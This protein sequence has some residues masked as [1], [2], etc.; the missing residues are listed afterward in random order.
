MLQG[1]PVVLEKLLIR[2]AAVMLVLTSTSYTHAQPNDRS[3]EVH[4]IDELIQGE[5][6]VSGHI[7]TGGAWIHDDFADGMSSMAHFISAS[8]VLDYSLAADWSL[9]SALGF[10][11]LSGHANRQYRPYEDIDGW[12]RHV[13][14]V[15]WWSSARF[16]V[17]KRFDVSFVVVSVDAAGGILV[18]RHTDFFEYMGIRD[19]SAHDLN[20][21]AYTDWNVAP[22]ATVN[23]TL[24]KKIVTSWNA[25]FGVE[26]QASGM[27]G[28]QFMTAALVGTVSHNL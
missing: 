7:T 12:T 24:T 3:D 19:N 27:F 2:L 6:T 16:G 25:G 15:S 20:P 17:R 21:H 9:T 1:V 23:A 18:R 11:Q 4:A 28:P 10:G 22:T 13:Q 26:L 14:F 8:T 5:W